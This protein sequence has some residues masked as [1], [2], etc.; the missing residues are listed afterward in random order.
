MTIEQQ[1]MLHWHLTCNHFPALSASLVP[2][3]QTAIELANSDAWDVYIE[4]PEGFVA[5]GWTVRELV[6]GLH[7]DGFILDY[8]D[9]LNDPEFDPE[10]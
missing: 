8:D 4:A 7:L 6:D 9:Y 2:I 5:K 3:A 10:D 1:V